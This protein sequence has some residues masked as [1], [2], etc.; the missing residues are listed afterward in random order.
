[1][2]QIF[3]SE[4]GASVR[5]KLNNTGLR[6]N[7]FGA[8]R[9]PTADD[10]SGEGYQAGSLW[11]NDSSSYMAITVDS[12]AAVWEPLGAQGTLSIDSDITALETRATALE[13]ATTTQRIVR[14]GSF[15]IGDSDILD[16]SRMFIMAGLSDSAVVTVPNGLTNSEYCTVFNRTSTRVS[17]AP[18]GGAEIIASANKQALI[19]RG[20]SAVL[21]KDSSD[22]F[23]LVGELDS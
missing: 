12:G 17:F 13:T 23:F 16:G 8:G 2:V 18:T 5:Q 21:Y 4:S 7:T 3:D 19:R 1:M 14:T 22:V 11:T 20:A 6:K 10:D 9:A 15:T